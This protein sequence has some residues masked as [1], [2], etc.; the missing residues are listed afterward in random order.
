M[1]EHL[2]TQ[3]LADLHHDAVQ[4]VI[5]T[6]TTVT[7]MLQA[8]PAMLADPQYKIIRSALDEA[9]ELAGELFTELM[10]R[11]RED[12]YRRA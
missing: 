9:S 5:A 8:G 4:R 3:Q 1:H 6:A 10:A 7:I 2:T 11:P 12:V